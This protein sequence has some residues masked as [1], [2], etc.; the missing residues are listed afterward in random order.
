MDGVLDRLRRIEAALTRYWP[1]VERLRT[2]SPLSGGGDGEV[3]VSMQPS[4]VTPGSYTLSSVTVDAYGRVTAASNGSGGASWPQWSPVTR[5]A[6][7]TEVVGEGD[8]TTGCRFQPIAQVL[9]TGVRFRRSAAIAGTMKGSI[10]DATNT[11]MVFGTTAVPATAG[12]YSVTWT[13]VSLDPHKR[14]VVGVW[15]TAAASGK[16][17]LALETDS[18]YVAPN[19]LSGALLW[20]HF[21]L[22]GIGD[23]IPSVGSPDGNL[24]NYGVEPIYQVV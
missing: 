11:R 20:E 3:L 21:A 5:S 6:S 13:G 23:A 16:F 15:D 24:A 2:L 1:R 22:Y 17:N 8:F 19:F 10:W 9:C 18:G 4:G 7:K 14:Y 12:T